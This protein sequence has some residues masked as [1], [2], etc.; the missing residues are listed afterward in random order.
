MSSAS[1]LGD[2]ARRITRISEVVGLDDDGEVEVRDIYRHVRRV[3]T[4]NGTM[5]EE[6]RHTGYLPLF[7]GQLLLDGEIQ[8]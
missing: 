6:F 1:R 7:L 3:D 8:L 4:V 2:G 5:K